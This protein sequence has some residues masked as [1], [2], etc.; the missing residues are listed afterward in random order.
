MIHVEFRGERSFKRIY[1][2]FPSVIPF[3]GFVSVPNL[4]KECIQ[5]KEE[6]PKPPK[7]HKTHKTHKTEA[8]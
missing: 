1:G 2:S 7:S 3:G 5:G 8:R 4:G 6:E